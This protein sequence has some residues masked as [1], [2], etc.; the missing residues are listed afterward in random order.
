MLARALRKPAAAPSAQYAHMPAPTG[1]LNKVDAGNVIPPTDCIYLYNMVAAANGLRVRTGFRE[2]VLGLTGSLSDVAPTLMG[3][4][5]SVASKDRLFACTDST[6]W[7]VSE[8][9]ED[10]PGDGLDVFTFATASA[11]SGYGVAQAVVTSAGHFL[12]Y[13]DE[14]N[15][16]HIYTESTDTWLAAVNGAGASE[17]Q[18]NTGSVDVADLVFPAIHKNR[19]WLVERDTASA[20]YNADAGSLYGTYHEFNFGRQ[21]RSGGHLVG[22]W[23]CTYDGGAG[24]DDV[25]VAISS[26][27]DVVIYRGNDVTDASDWALVG[28]WQV[29]GVVGG[30]RI[31]TDRG[32]DL[33]IATKLGLLPLSQLVL[34]KAKEAT[35][36]YDT[37]KISSLFS[38]LASSTRGPL[39]QWGLHIH[40]TDS[41][42]VVLVPT[43]AG[44]ATNQLAMSLSTHAWS[45]YADLPMYAA[46]AW[47]GDFWFT[48]AEGG[49]VTGAEGKV[50]KHAG[51]VDDVRLAD[52]SSTAIEWRAFTGYTDLGRPTNKQIG[53]IRPVLLSGQ[54]EPL[55]DVVV[56][57]DWDLSEPAT[58]TGNPNQEGEGWDSDLW[59]AG[60]WGGE[61]SPNLS[62]V[63]AVGMG[64]HFAIAIRGRAVSRT[65]LVGFDISLVQSAGGFL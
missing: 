27:G 34:G 1:G 32:G 18:A 35:E 56:R 46:T 48:G 31:A 20:W 37:Y 50:Y 26:G 60:I 40:P 15:G 8:E 10:A 3:F 29:G 53:M 49:G 61:L 41:T 19:V 28:T 55:Y 33:V 22:L 23:S 63:G 54:S 38:D 24:M 14:V 2:W 7:D 16:L 12:L 62:A 59:D 5:G 21:F 4:K 42:L 52:D 25:L 44:S 39:T 17:I 43:A 11:S 36:Q 6:I 45:Q 65:T 13:C 47:A 30:R 51:D 57:Y 58:P 64:K 9:S